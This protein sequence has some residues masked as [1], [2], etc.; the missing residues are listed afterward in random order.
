VKQRTRILFAGISPINITEIIIILTYYDKP[1]NELALANALLFTSTVPLSETA[2]QTSRPPLHCQIGYDHQAGD[3]EKLMGRRITILSV[4]NELE[5]MW[6][7]TV[8]T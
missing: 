6:N 5:M 1:A 3:K 4:N 2:P 8:V 7:G